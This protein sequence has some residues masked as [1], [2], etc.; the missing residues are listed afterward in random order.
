MQTQVDLYPVIQPNN[1]FKGM[2]ICREMSSTISG[3]VV[4]K[5]LGRISFHQTACEI[6][7][8]KP[9]SLL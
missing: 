9:V 7:H 5:N 8:Y 2:K 3:A 1:V 6:I 4:E